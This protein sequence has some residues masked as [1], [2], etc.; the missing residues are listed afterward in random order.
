V[1]RGIELVCDEKAIEDVL[2][3]HCNHYLGLKP[4]ARQYRTS[5]GIIDLLARH[6]IS[7]NIYFVIEIKRGTLDSHAY[8]QVLR[9]CKWLNSEQSKNGQR[10]FFPILV[11]EQ[12][13]T[14][15][16]HLCNFFDVDSYSSVPAIHNVAYRLFK[17]DPLAG[18][19]F[20][21]LSVSQRDAASLYFE[22]HCHVAQLDERA[23]L[24]EWQLQRS[25]DHD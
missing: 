8:T 11:G 24:A 2:W 13:S 6:P 23:S 17:F 20:N 16:D 15:L 25:P 1:T 14:N 19:T 12:L 10:I 22:N 21:Y 5:V 3:D 4:I 7:P 9:Y 18:I